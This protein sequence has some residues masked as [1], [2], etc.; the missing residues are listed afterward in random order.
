MADPL[1]IPPVTI[2]AAGDARV[3]RT[4]LRRERNSRYGPGNSYKTRHQ[5][6][7]SA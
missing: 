6:V 2:N 7:S 5:S 4:L 3:G 1:K